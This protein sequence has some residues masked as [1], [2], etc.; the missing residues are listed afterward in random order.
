MNYNALKRHFYLE[1][2]RNFYSHLINLFRGRFS[3]E[4]NIGEYMAIVNQLKAIIQ[5]NFSIE[6]GSFCKNLDFIFFSSIVSLENHIPEIE[7]RSLLKKLNLS[8]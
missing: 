7:A 5:L 4:A 8:Q 6:P 2:S 3:S 1:K